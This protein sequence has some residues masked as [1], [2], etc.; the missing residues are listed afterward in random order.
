MSLTSLVSFEDGRTDGYFSDKSTLTLCGSSMTYFSPSGLKTQF[1]MSSLQADSEVT[2]KLYCLAE[3]FNR[4]SES[5]LPLY[6]SSDFSLKLTRITS[7]SWPNDISA[8]APTQ[9]GWRVASLDGNASLELQRD[10]LLVKVEYLQPVGEKQIVQQDSFEF[11]TQS[12]LRKYRRDYTHWDAGDRSKDTVTHKHIR[13]SKLYSVGHLPSPWAYP[14]GLVWAY[15]ESQLAFKEQPV[16]FP[17]G[18]TTT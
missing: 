16:L 1:Q 4:Y 5:S 12:L 18:Y 2:P 14:C 7:Y 9:D 6:K 8:V 15:L 11:T 10:L 3:V 17:E 13:M